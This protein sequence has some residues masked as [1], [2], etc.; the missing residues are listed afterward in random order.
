MSCNG[1]AQTTQESPATSPAA[2]KASGAFRSVEALINESGIKFDGYVQGGFVRNDVS[3]VNERPG[4]LSNYPLPQ[5]GD[6]NLSFNT[7]QTFL[8]KD[9]EGNVQ[10]RVGPK[11]GQVATAVSWGFMIE[12]MYGR[13]GQAARMFGFKLN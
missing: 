4:G 6:E 8:H 12:S 2:G 3:T 5:V 7:I 10:P 1:L 9:V 11:P 13:N